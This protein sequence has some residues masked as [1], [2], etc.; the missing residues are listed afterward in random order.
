MT[1][2]IPQSKV[3]KVFA[4]PAK[5]SNFETKFAEIV[6][7]NPKLSHRYTIQ[8]FD[9]PVTSNYAFTGSD[10]KSINILQLLTV[11]ELDAYRALKTQWYN[12]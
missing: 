2:R 9:T 12:S 8:F 5:K 10:G 4:T 3:A 1:V 11:N 7:N 6:Q